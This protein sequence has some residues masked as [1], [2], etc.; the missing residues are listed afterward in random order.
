MLQVDTDPDDNHSRKVCCQRLCGWFLT[1]FLGLI[2]FST[3]WTPPPLL[4]FPQG[5]L[6]TILCFC[7]KSEGL[8]AFSLL[9]N[10]MTPTST[11]WS[12]SCQSSCS[13]SKL[14][15]AAGPLL[16]DPQVLDSVLLLCRLQP[17]QPVSSPAPKEPG[18]EARQTSALSCSS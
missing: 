9:N 18:Y 10:E 3:V 16:L 8:G 7:M 5:G 11:S 6:S 2:V 12:G 4:H 15:T 1:H 13:L 17:S 14:S